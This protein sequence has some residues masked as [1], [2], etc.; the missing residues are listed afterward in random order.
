MVV[1]IVFMLRQRWLSLFDSGNLFSVTREGQI[2]KLA[3]ALKLL[4]ALPY[5]AITLSAE[6]FRFGAEDIKNALKEN[7][8]PIVISNLKT[9]EGN[10]PQG[11]KNSMVTISCFPRKMLFLPA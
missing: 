6:D 2:A 11:I 4:S 8:I 10:S 3:G 1:E 5:T 9:K 7:K